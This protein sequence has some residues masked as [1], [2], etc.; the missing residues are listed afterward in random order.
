M[1][2]TW[3]RGTHGHGRASCPRPTKL[4]LSLG[5]RTADPPTAREEGNRPKNS[6]ATRNGYRRIR[7][8]DPQNCDRQYVQRFEGRERREKQGSS[9]DAFGRVRRC[10]SYARVRSCTATR[11]PEGPDSTERWAI[12]KPRSSLG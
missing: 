4:G 7:A 9:R 10:G 11:N 6:Q 3:R 12:L 2:R 8:C 5:W 1:L